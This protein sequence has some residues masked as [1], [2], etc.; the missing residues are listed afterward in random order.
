MQYYRDIDG[1]ETYIR[2]TSETKPTATNF[3]DGFR[4]LDIDLGIWY[5]VS[6]GV[7][8]VD[9][10]KYNG[11][12]YNS[13]GVLVNTSDA[14]YDDSFTTE[15]IESRY[16]RQGCVYG[17]GYTWSTV[18]SNA[19][20]NI[21]MKIGAKPIY[22]SGTI[23]GVA[24]SDYGLVTGATITAN[25]TAPTNDPFGLAVGVHAHENILQ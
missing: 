8:I 23:A 25:G 7:W 3:I 15:T 12:V 1:R 11:S 22:M 5:A 9:K 13:D 10:S 18:V 2:R 21:Y 20:V 4:Y 14:Y 16:F 17:A 19:T 6:N 24:L